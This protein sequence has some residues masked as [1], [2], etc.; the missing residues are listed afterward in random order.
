ML[1]RENRLKKRYQYNYVY[2]V[3]KKVSGTAM[4]IYATTSKTKNIK[5][6]FSVTKKVGKATRR[7]LARRRLREIVRKQLPNLKQNYN[8]I[9]VAKDNILS[10]SFAE[11]SSEFE[12]LLIKLELLNKSD[13]KSI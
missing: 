7:N 4:T 3:G 10:K 12:S 6:G 5:V 11:L 1:K 13:E 9:I 8:I 2:K